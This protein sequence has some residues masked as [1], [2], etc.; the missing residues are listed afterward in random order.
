[1]SSVTMSPMSAQSVGLGTIASALVRSE[2]VQVVA[3]ASLGYYATRCVFES[4]KMDLNRATIMQEMRTVPAFLLALFIKN[5]D[6]LQIL[7]CAFT[8]SSIITNIYLSTYDKGSRFE[9][10]ERPEQS[11]EDVVGNQEAKQSLQ[12]IAQ[13]LIHPKQRAKS[14]PDIKAVLLYGEP[15]NGKTMMARA[16]AYEVSKEGTNVAFFAANGA[17]FEGALIGSGVKAIEGLFKAA[18]RHLNISYRER[19]RNALS[20][21]TFGYI[22]PAAKR[23]SVIF[24]DEIDVLARERMGAEGSS[25]NP[26]ANGLPNA[27]LGQL[28]GF[29]AIE[30]I[31]IVGATNLLGNL[32]DAASSRFTEK[33]EVKL[34]TLEERKAI[35]SQ[36]IKKEASE[37]VL[38]ESITKLCKENIETFARNAESFSGRDLENVVKIARRNALIANREIVEG[39][40]LLDKEDFDKAIDE[41]QKAKAAK[42]EQADGIKPMPRSVKAMYM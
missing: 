16:F 9:I 32:S 34:P 19:I 27:F 6:S 38:P 30:G 12:S 36:Y 11:F 20:R 25:N 40:R 37:A 39:Y 41:I 10:K 17:D 33:I 35:L 42:K 29:S 24:I 8:I 4:M 2:L 22:E 28:E 21:W 15:G 14:D 26:Y 13:G 23:H 18:K 5:Q 7:L 1:M 31:T 3:A